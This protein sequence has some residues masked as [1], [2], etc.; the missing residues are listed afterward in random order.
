MMVNITI[1]TGAIQIDQLREKFTIYEKLIFD[2]DDTILSEDWFDYLAFKSIAIEFYSMND[3][4][5]DLYSRKGIIQKR[6]NRKNL[7]NRI[8]PD[9]DN[10]LISS[11]VDYYQNF[12]CGSILQKYSIRN[13]LKEMHKEGKKIYI[14][15]NGHPLR[16]MNK[17]NDL[18]IKHFLSDI[19]ICHPST[20]NP[21]KPSG[22]VLDKIGITKGA[23]NC[24]MIGDNTLID[25]SFAESRSIEFY[26]FKFPKSNP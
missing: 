6:I 11:I 3:F 19:Y 17:I 2:L 7:F 18:N 21:L 26:L 9:S 4:D 1:D 15:T 8:S 12:K 25:G 22:S 20:N 24:L 16:Q 13:I 14:V 10:E 23:K 5:S